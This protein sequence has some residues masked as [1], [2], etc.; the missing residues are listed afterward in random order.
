MIDL[1]THTKFYNMRSPREILV[2]TTS[3]V[4]GFNIKQYLRPISSHVVAG[5]NFFSDFFASFTD[6]FGGRSGTYQN[7]LVSLYNESIERLR[8][9]AFEIG[10]NSIVGLKVDMDEISGK[11]K[12]MFMVTAVG[13]AVLIEGRSKI[14]SQIF[15]DKKV[16]NASIEK[17]KMLQKKREIIGLAK[18]G[19]L[20][21][22]DDVWDFITKQ[23]VYEVY[24]F[25]IAK[26]QN[27]LAY[28][29]E[30]ADVTKKVYEKTLN[31][32]DALPEFRKYDLLYGSVSSTENQQ[33]FLKIAEL[34]DDLRMFDFDRIMG[35]LEL[36]DF[37]K[38]KRATKIAVLDKAF[39]SKD[40]IDK[41]RKI[42]NEIQQRFKERG[43]R[44]MKKQ[45]IGKE[46]E[47]WTCECGKTNTLGNY[48][49][50]CKRDIFG[51]TSTEVSPPEALKVIEEKISLISECV[52]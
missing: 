12:S 9:A 27:S 22:D 29:L 43:A 17:I 38:Q 23:Q 5:T 19:E 3:T 8:E 16:E 51:F 25:V 49:S 35:I 36:N 50:G 31:F 1:A 4:D 13:T 15:E 7:Q 6:V 34:V 52:V 2:T 30:Q 26:L 48:C 14:G 21:L 28:A 33:L 40:D 42:S 45:L 39:Y 37:E 11:G 24:E 47:V 18:S 46:K 44:S 10:A 41:F 20:K 32:I